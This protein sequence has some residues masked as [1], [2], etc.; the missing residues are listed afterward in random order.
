MLLLFYDRKAPCS[1]SFVQCVYFACMCVCMNVLCL[2]NALLFDITF[3]TLDQRSA[4]L[5]FDW[6]DVERRFDQDK[7]NGWPEV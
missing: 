7:P 2:I 1:L 3:F 6:N 5:Q 4:I